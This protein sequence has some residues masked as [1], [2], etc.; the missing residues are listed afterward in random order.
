MTDT[1]ATS[2]DLISAPIDVTVNARFC[3]PP[4]SGNGGY[5]C[6]LMAR[7]LP[8]ARA[9]TA[10]LVKPVPLDTALKLNPAGEGVALMDGGA[11]I[12][13]AKPAPALDLDVPPCPAPSAVEAATSRYP[14]HGAGH[15]FPR[16]FVCGPDRAK[17]DGLRIFNGTVQGGPL[18]A[19]PWMPH[20]NLA[21]DSG[22]VRMEFI[23]AAL[24]CPTY[25]SFG[26][27][28]FAALLGRMTAEIRAPV[29]AEQAHT[30]IAWP[31]SSEGRKHRAGSALYTAD[32]TLAAVAGT[33]WIELKD[34]T[35]H[36]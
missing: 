34:V 8:D 12:G 1:T 28:R 2:S 25:W 3:G 24:D 19:A 7:H 11:L 6:G 32:G 17:G 21:G 35:P 14:G 31:V 18:T 10:S 5:A 30:V 13:T 15:I 26:R 29:P 16:C 4:R 22:R 20:G 27:E 23:W 9:I 36:V 33:L